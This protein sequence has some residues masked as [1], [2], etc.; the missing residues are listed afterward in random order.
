MAN[1]LHAAYFHQPDIDPVLIRLWGPLQIRWYSLLYVGGFLVARAILR[2]LAKKERFL[3]DE[4]DVEQ[5]ILWGLIG[6]VAGARI[7]Y[8]VVYDPSA[9][10][11]NPLYLLQIY[12]GGLSFHGGLIGLILT[13]IFF[14]RKK[15]IPFWNLG[16]AIAL[17][18]PTG[19]GMGR[20]G[21]F[22]N[23]ELYG[24]VSYV[25]WAIIFRDGGFEPRHPSQLY[26]FL[27]EGVLLFALLWLLRNRC[28]RDGQIS[29]LF[30][31]GYAVSRFIVE[32]FR[33]PDAHIGY[34]LLRLSM[35]QWLSVIMFVISTLVLWVLWRRGWKGRFSD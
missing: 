1:E 20:I 35:G 7:F 23:G 11:A 19:L 27:L 8:C 13:V 12:R 5:L 28:Q 2:R 16:D 32:F 24:R 3:F 6:S 22:I 29:M 30:L 26:E 14:G 31:M 15:K 10:L 25:P 33:E 17:A 18:A 9:L 21:N 4:E 34:L